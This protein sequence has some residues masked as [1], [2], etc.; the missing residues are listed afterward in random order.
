MKVLKIITPL[1]FL[2]FLSV[3][4]VLAQELTKEQRKEIK[5]QEEE[6]SL[7]EEIL[8]NELK[9]LDRIKIRFEKEKAK[10]KLSKEEVTRKENIIKSVETRLNTL[11]TKINNQKITLISY[12][13][14]LSIEVAEEEIVTIPTKITGGNLNERELALQAEK[15]RLEKEMKESEAAYLRK[16]EELKARNEKLAELNSQLKED[17]KVAMETKERNQKIAEY[18]DEIS[19]NQEMLES[20]KEGLI[21]MKEK[22][23]SAKEKGVLSEEVIERRTSLIAKLETKLKNLEKEIQTKQEAIKMLH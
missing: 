3:Q 18:E 2:S 7:N 21:K 14:S 9:G 5:T 23:S 10:G 4:G 13:K 8:T 1:V 11:A 15:A 17:K 22:F 19:I 16:Q 12:K 20:G 6:I